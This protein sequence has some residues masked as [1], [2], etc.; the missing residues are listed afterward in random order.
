MTKIPEHGT[1]KIL[2]IVNG[3]SLRNSVMTDD[4]LLE[5]FLN[6]GGGYIGYRLCFNPFGEVLH[7]NDGEGVI[8]LC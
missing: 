5:E 4:V 3:D 2:G 7:C 6:C 1:I 8:S